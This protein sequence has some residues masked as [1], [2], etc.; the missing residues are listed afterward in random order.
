MTIDTL[1]SIVLQG[2]TLGM[3]FFLIASGLSLIFGLMDVLNFA[4]G[5]IFMIGGYVAWA[6]TEALTPS[7]TNSDLIFALSLLA[8]TL[9]GAALG[10]AIEYLGIRPLYKRPIFQVLLTLGLVFVFTE[11][12]KWIWGGSVHTM[13]K[14]ESLAG[15]AFILGRP[16][17][18]YRLFLIV[19]GFAVLGVIWLLLRRS[20]VGLIIRAGVENPE[21]VQALGID[22]RKAFTLVFALGSGMAALGGAAAAPFLGLVPELGID[23]Q[24]N[25]FV[26]VIIGGL[27][28]FPGSAAGAILVGLGRAFADYQLSPLLA[29]ATVVGLMALVLLI[30]PTGLFGVKKGGGH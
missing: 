4:H 30:K 23:Y 21:M 27:G 16:F 1:I 12:V 7:V 9:V 17:P 10:A 3:L 24:L 8:G 13:A 14:P 11:L 22:V 26:V 19:L 18:L 5:S 29:R 6:T 20:R 15:A 28:S 2:L 25:A